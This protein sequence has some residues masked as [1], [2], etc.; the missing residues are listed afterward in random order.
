MPVQGTIAPNSRAVVGIV[1]QAAD[2]TPTKLDG[3]LQAVFMEPAAFTIDS[4]DPLNIILKCDPPA[5]ITA[6][7]QT[8]CVISD[9]ADSDPTLEI[10]FD[11]QA[12]VVIIKA[13]QFGT[14]ITSEPLA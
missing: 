10:L 3:N 9:D 2:G 7:P 12:A 14:T 4:T 11:W 1:P 6:Q 8:H 5:D 13:T